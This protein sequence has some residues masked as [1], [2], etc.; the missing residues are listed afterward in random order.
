[1]ESSSSSLSSTVSDGVL[2]L[3]KGDEGKGKVTEYILRTEN[4]NVCMRF[5]GGPNAGHTIFFKGK[6]G[7]ER[8]IVLHQIPSGI[9]NP[10]MICIIGPGCVVDPIKLMKEIEEVQNA[11][12]EI[13]DRLKIAYNAHVITAEAIAQDKANDKIGTTGSGIGP[14]YSAKYSREGKRVEHVKTEIPNGIEI[15]NVYNFFKD[16]FYSMGVQL[17]IMFEGAQGYDLDINSSMYPYVTS[18]GCTVADAF[19]GGI[20]VPLKSLRK[21]FGVAKIYETYVGKFQFQPENDKALESIQTE[22]KEFGAT[23]GRKRQCNWLNLSKLIEA[24]LVNSVTDLIINKCDIFIKV[25]VFKL[26]ENGAL[27]NFETFEEMRDYIVNSLVLNTEL[28][29]SR[30]R[31]SFSPSEI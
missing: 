16:N 13:G 17:R 10:T 24:V 1:M 15:I 3:Q 19:T 11:G 2:G 29:S 30:I 27:V 22:G 8:K 9:L 18:S 5:N 26:Y 28:E 6:D 23:T 14:T 31:F 25:G 4:H 7:V 21:V 12:V 20:G